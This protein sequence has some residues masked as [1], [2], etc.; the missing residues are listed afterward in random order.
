MDKSVFPSILRAA[1]SKGGDY[2]DIFFEEREDTTLRLEQGKIKSIGGGNIRGMGIRV[3]FGRQFVYGYLSD[4]D[5][6]SCLD[7]AGRIGAAAASGKSGLLPPENLSAPKICP[8]SLYPG[9][10]SMDRKI[11]M[12]RRA[13]SA[14]REASSTVRDVIINYIDFAQRVSIATSLGRFYEDERV[15]T[16]FSVTTLHQKGERKESG[17]YGPG[18]S[19]GFEFFEELPPEAVAREAARIGDVMIIAGTAPQGKMPVII[20]NGFGGVLFHEACGHALE[21]TSVAD[22]ASVFSGKLGQPIASGIVNAFDDGTIPNAWGSSAW[23]DEGEPTKKNHLIKDGILSSYMVD[24]L[25]SYKMDLPVT[26]NGRRESYIFAPT[27]R[28]TNTYIAPGKDTLPD[29]ILSIDDGLYC[30]SLGGGSV[31]PATTEFNFAAAESY[32]IRKGKLAEPVKGASL[33]G[34]GSEILT[35]ICMVADNL[36]FGTGMCGSLSGSIPAFV[37]QPA[38][39]VDGLVVGGR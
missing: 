13:D 15:R 38:I 12:A 19:K 23:D 1:L 28:M 3:I 2:A 32:R 16:R 26:G 36:D 29:M 10:I 14:G 37:G 21:A 27:S 5:E 7:L 20:D 31:H 30:K 11:E 4:P 39:K 35:K 17:F 24:R 34:K 22:G 18:R 6:K 33:I 8:V 25:G 9:S